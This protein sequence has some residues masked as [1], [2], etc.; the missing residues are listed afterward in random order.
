MKKKNY[1]TKTLKNVNKN[2]QKQFENST[3][4]I[5]KNIY[6]LIRRG[7]SERDVLI[8]ESRTFFLL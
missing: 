1:I 2:R 5:Q 6:D 8:L 7:F 3:S 4:M